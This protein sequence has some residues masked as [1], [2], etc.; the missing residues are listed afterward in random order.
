VPGVLY[1]RPFTF[2]EGFFVWPWT[3]FLFILSAIAVGP[4]FTLL[5]TWILQKVTKRKLVKYDVLELLGKISGILLC[6]Y[7]VFKSWDTL[8]WATHTLPQKGMTI[9]E[10]YQGWFGPY[11]MWLLVAELGIF[12]VVP[13]LILICPALRKKEFWLILG[14]FFNCIGILINRFVFTIV[15]WGIPTYPFDKWVFYSPSWQE[16]ATTVMPVALGVIV[17]SLSYRYLPVFPQERE[18]NP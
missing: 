16:V 11:G 1:S 12:G 15:A 10:L 18:L 5:C 2:R 13:A 17:V 6:V 3:F 8:Y 14:A 7:L 9:T 4:S